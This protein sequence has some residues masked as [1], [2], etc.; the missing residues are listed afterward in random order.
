MNVKQ[1]KVT[2]NIPVNEFRNVPGVVYMQTSHGNHFGFVEGS[3]L[4]AFSS[5]HAYTYPA[6]VALTFFET[7][8]KHRAKASN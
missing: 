2:E 5:D 4:E 1:D 6:K 8:G 3:L 7:V